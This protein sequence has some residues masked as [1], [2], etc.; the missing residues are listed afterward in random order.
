MRHKSPNGQQYEWM[1]SYSLL[2]C[3]IWP[4]NFTLISHVITTVPWI[5]LLLLV[6]KI[7]SRHFDPFFFYSQLTREKPSFQWP[8]I[9]LTQ[10]WSNPSENRQLD[11]Y[12]PCFK[13]FSPRWIC[14][15]DWQIMRQ[16]YNT[17]ISQFSESKKKNGTGP[18]KS[19]QLFTLNH[20]KRHNSNF[21]SWL[22]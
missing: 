9:K 11:V 3:S 5:Q 10:S 21:H 7:P 20:D 13:L 14:D 17:S 1:I 22:I 6:I 16:K 2:V 4:W 15:R 18:I 8:A 12:S 19:G